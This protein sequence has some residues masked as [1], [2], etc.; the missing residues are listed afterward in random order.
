MSFVT[1]SAP[2][3]LGPHGSLLLRASLVCALLGQGACGALFNEKQ[4]LVMIESSPP[5]ANIEIGG[6]R[7]G[8]TPFEVTVP[9]NRPTTVVVEHPSHGT[10]VCMIDPAIEPLWILLDIWFLVPLVVDAVTGR[11]SDVPSHCMVVLGKG[12]APEVR[13]APVPVVSPPPSPKTPPPAGD[14]PKPFPFPK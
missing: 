11:W 7:V 2:R 9:T 14:K 4:R 13:D 8:R 12:R 1:A 6:Q 10:S 3:S 5:G